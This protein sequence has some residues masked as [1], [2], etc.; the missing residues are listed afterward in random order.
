MAHLKRASKAAT[1]SRMCGGLVPRLASLTATLMLGACAQ[2]ADL[3]PK[4]ALASTDDRS[5]T[6]KPEVAQNELQKATTYWGQEYAKSPMELKP[7]LS[8]ARNLKALGE[9]EKA[10]AI[11]QRAASMHD[12]DPELAG[13]YGRLAL[14]LD[15]VNVAARMLELADDAAKPDWKVISARGTVM[16]KQSKYKEAIPYYER[17]LALAPNQSSVLNNLAMAYAMGGDPK[18]AE[19]LLRQA[20][21]NPAQN[22]AKVKQ[23]LA[24]VLGLQGR[25]DEAKAITAG[26]ASAMASSDNVDIMR[27]IVK[28]DAKPAATAVAAVPDFKTQ[29]SRAIATAP[30]APIATP[31]SVSGA[32][33]VPAFKTATVDAPAAPATVWK[34]NVASGAPAAVAQTAIA[35]AAPEGSSSTS[36]LKGSAP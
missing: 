2:S 20:A 19:E 8:Y 17:A 16:A 33:T 3:L 27:K 4:A 22:S 5:S 28:I 24:L 11:L 30:A 35:Q 29:V 18:K 14:E 12:S 15:Q 7:A 25:Y 31:V 9:K 10:L 23:N 36:G 21:A 6:D 1:A 34:T 13:E 26:S 32:Q